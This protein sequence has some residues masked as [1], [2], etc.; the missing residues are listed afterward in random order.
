MTKHQAS[1]AD[2]AVFQCGAERPTASGTA[3]GVPWNRGSFGPVRLRAPGSVSIARGEASEAAA[4]REAVLI[5][6]LGSDQEVKAVMALLDRLC[7]MLTRLAGL[8]HK[9]SGLRT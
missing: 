9:S 2:E 5:L 1:F 6:R 8:T 3:V 4:A 7:A